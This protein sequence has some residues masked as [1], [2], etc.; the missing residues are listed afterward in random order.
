MPYS[1]APRSHTEFGGGPGLI[2]PVARLDRTITPEEELIEIYATNPARPES[3]NVP[4]NEQVSPLGPE[5]FPE[6]A[7]IERP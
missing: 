7:T 4:A 6:T 3:G 1:K 5:N 2:D